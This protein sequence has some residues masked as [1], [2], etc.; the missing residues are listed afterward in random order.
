M[1]NDEIRAQ[2]RGTATEAG[3]LAT[4]DA[5]E[6]A[7]LSTIETAIS[8][9]N[10]FDASEAAQTLRDLGLAEQSPSLAGKVTLTHNGRMLAQK[11]R[12]SRLNGPERWDAV[13]RAIIADLIERH[14]QRQRL[15]RPQRR[16][17]GG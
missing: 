16:W 1:N 7:H 6:Q 13:E 14:P 4:F 11:I 17:P 9:G 8:G 2:I 12:Q 3:L 5:G 10:A 15:G